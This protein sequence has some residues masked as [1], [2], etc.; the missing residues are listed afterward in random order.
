[1]VTP[2]L[3]A[4]GAG[5]RPGTPTNRGGP[6]DRRQALK[7]K[8][9]GEHRLTTAASV[10][11]ILAQRKLLT[12]AKSEVTVGCLDI[13]RLKLMLAKARHEQFVLL[14]LNAAG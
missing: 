13:E 12:L 10:V 6:V 8:A 11:R 9:C 2:G 7:R 3:G 14:L 1:V 5:V 4:P